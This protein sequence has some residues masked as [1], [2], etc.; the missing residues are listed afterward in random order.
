MKRTIAIVLLLASCLF[1][2][3]QIKYIDRANMDFSVKPG[4]DFFQYANGGWLKKAVMPATKTR[5]G[6]F[7]MLREE[8]S[9]Q[10]KTLLETAAAKTDRTRAEQMCGDFYTSGMDSLQLEKLKHAREGLT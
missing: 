1:S 3:A 8:S 6:S 9:R 10:L 5:W 4:D 2:N 7:D